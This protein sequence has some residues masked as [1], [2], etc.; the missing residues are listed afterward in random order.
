MSKKQNEK[1]TEKTNKKRSQMKKRECLSDDGGDLLAE[2][3]SPK[4]KRDAVH[5]PTS[6]K[7][8]KTDV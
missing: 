1:W 6:T 2:P 5:V 8:S 3:L 4:K 7:R